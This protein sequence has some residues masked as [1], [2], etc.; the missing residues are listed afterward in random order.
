MA[1]TR[2]IGRICLVAAGLTSLC[3]AQEKTRIQNTVERLESKLE[4]IEN[5]L[6]SL[7]GGKPTPQ[8]TEIQRV[9][10]AA[11]ETE[12]R[13]TARAEKLEKSLDALRA[14]R[15]AAVERE[16][17]NA[18]VIAELEAALE[19]ARLE[20]KRAE[21]ARRRVEDERAKSKKQSEHIVNAELALLSAARAE[22][23]RLQLLNAQLRKD[24]E[25]SRGANGSLQRQLHSV[26]RAQATL[27]TRE[28][29][30]RARLETLASRAEDDA[31]AS[32]AEARESESELAAARR[33]LDELRR[34]NE[35]LIQQLTAERKRLRQL[36]SSLE[37]RQRAPKTQD[38]QARRQPG[39]G[40]SVGGNIEVT[41]HGGTV[42]LQI[43]SGEID[44]DNNSPEGVE[45][46]GESE[47]ESEA[48]STSVR[49]EGTGREPP[50]PA[51]LR[52]PET[53][54]RPVEEQKR[55]PKQRGK[56]NL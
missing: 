28:G 44:M 24:L 23:R 46:E 31:R 48:G 43:G 40:S 9:R 10:A 19:R 22:T 16:R 13:L 33:E 14:E 2:S 51:S 26:R 1:N 54:L 36:S 34:D 39:T 35:T 30:L 6:Q 11:A 17:Q 38:P 21:T 5:V 45:A 8:N 52:L 41:N 49:H 20:A 18:K 4:Q 7:E 29:D 37:A 53:V 47:G 50:Q 3:L 25:E 56:I 12:S 55:K 32:A 42:I 15:D 27:E